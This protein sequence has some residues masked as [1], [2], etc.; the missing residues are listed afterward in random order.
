[1]FE[2]RTQ[3]RLL[4]VPYKGGAPAINDTLAGSIDA[5]YAVMPEAIAHIKAGKLHALG[6]M[7][8]QRSAVLPD[9]PTMVEAG[10]AHL[11]LSAWI[12]LLAPAKTPLAIID[13]LNRAVQAALDAD[14][15]AKLAENGM[16]VATSSPE[17]LQRLIARD[18]QLHAE[19]VKAA[20]L[21]PQ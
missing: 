11:S 17:E 12:G 20:G 1:M 18:V 21:T 19:L 9:T 13:Q 10:F 5:M 14:V 6:V 7:S 15:K 2:T 8:P 4:H 3:T 16:Q